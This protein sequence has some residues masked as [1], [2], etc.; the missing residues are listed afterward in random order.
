M[1]SNVEVTAVLAHPGDILR[2]AGGVDH[3]HVPVRLA[4]DDHVIDDPAP[5]VAHDAVEGT[6]DL[7]ARDVIG[8]QALNVVEGPVA[9]ET[10]LA[11]VRQVEEATASPDRHV[12]LADRRVL[13]RHVEAAE[14][15]HACPGGDVPVVQRGSRG[16]GLASV[17]RC[18][19]ASK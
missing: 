14:L 9:G 6:A 11:H 7:E 8:D 4:V 13:Q 19:T 12:L 2:T 5:V 17:V 15:D 3:H 1:S 16:H 10:H 18:Q